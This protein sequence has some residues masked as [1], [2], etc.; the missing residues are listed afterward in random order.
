[1]PASGKFFASARTLATAVADGFLAITHNSFALLGLAVAFVALTL[2]ARP[3]LRVAGETQLR[4]WLDARQVPVAVADAAEEAGPV[5]AV[6]RATAANPKA[7]PKEQAAVAYWLS[8]KYRV[9]PEPI[10]AL[11]A[12]AYKQGQANKLDPTLILS[13]MAIESSFNPFAQSAVGAQ[14]LMQVMTSVHTDK[15]ESFGGRHAAFDPVTNL[16]VGVKVLKEC[17]ARAGSIEGGLRHY[18]G[19]ANLE[20]DGGYAAKVL[21]EHQRLRLAVG[22]RA[23]PILTASV[24]PKDAA[25]VA[26]ASHSDA[27]DKPAG[28][29]AKTAAVNTPSPVTRLSQATDQVALAEPSI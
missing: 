29:S 24:K 28:I 5:A 27:A 10:A 22:L 21:A 7:L 18:V 9:A 15:Y 13:V 8:K 14:G 26:G 11:V 20:S 19:A 4:N 23:E 12:E 1:M 16:R 6:D 25:P 3:D 17:I 2:F